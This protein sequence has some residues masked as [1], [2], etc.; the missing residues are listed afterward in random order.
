[1][2]LNGKSSFEALSAGERE[3]DEKETSYESA[4]AE[5]CREPILNAENLVYQWYEQVDSENTTIWAN[6]HGAD[7]NV[8]LVE[9]NIRKCVFYPKQEKDYITVSGFELAQGGVPVCCRRRK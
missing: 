7:P 2:Y 8:E 6:F 5:S 1:M 4:L 9:I 3:K